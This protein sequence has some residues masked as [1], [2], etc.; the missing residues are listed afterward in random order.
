MMQAMGDVGGSQGYR[1]LVRV[2]SYPAL[3]SSV[4]LAR[5]V[6]SEGPLHGSVSVVRNPDAL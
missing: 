1:G 5:L 4:A 2:P 3:I 6:R